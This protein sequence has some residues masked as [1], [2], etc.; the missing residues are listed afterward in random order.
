MARRA[1]GIGR[2]WEESLDT[3]TE[4]NA[5]IRRALLKRALA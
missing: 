4:L 3:L 1:C 5:E 2:S